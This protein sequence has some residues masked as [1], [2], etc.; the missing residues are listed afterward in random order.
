QILHS[1][2][3]VAFVNNLISV[4]PFLVTE[5][6]TYFKHYV[7]RKNQSGNRKQLLSVVLL[8]MPSIFFRINNECSRVPPNFINSI[9]INLILKIYRMWV[10]PSF[11]SHVSPFFSAL[12]L[13]TVYNKRINY[14]SEFSQNPV[15]IATTYVIENHVGLFKTSDYFS[16]ASLT[17]QLGGRELATCVGS[18]KIL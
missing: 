12:I 6:A 9:K 10:I 8:C 2:D 4:N 13:R 16:I 1:A 11:R 17:T 7:Q 15:F 5:F 3:V 14:K 18:F